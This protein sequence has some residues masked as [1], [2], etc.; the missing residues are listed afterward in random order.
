MKKLLKFLIIVLLIGI[1]IYFFCKEGIID[2][3]KLK[4][5]CGGCCGRLFGG[6]GSDD[7]IFEEE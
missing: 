2:V 4:E 6:K 5:K 7:S 3:D 1:V